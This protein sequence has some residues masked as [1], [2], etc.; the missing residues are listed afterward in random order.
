MRRCSCTCA[1]RGHTCCS[2]CVCVCLEKQWPPCLPVRSSR[3]S[4]FT[5]VH[6]TLSG[7]PP[8]PNKKHT[9]PQ[10]APSLPISFHFLSVLSLH[11]A[12]AFSFCATKNDTFPTVGSVWMM[13]MWPLGHSYYQPYKYGNEAISSTSV[14]FLSSF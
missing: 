13:H 9:L 5:P 3:S 6:A 7:T 8:T 14:L 12:L 2:L 4:C 11:P 10:S 1:G